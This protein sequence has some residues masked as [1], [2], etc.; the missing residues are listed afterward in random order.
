VPKNTFLALHWKRRRRWRSQH[1]HDL[2]ILNRI[3]WG[4][5]VQIDDLTDPLG[6]RLLFDGFVERSRYTFRQEDDP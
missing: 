5:L 4:D 2:H 6:K 1:F 3:L